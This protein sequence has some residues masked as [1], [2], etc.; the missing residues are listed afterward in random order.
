M[1]PCVRP[2]C[3][4]T[5]LCQGLCAVLCC[6]SLLLWGAEGV[7]A[8]PCPQLARYTREGFLHLGALGTTTLL[9]D[10]RCLVDTGKSRFPQLLDCDKVKSSLHKR[11][12]FIQVCLG[13][14]LG[15]LCC[16]NPGWDTAH[17][18]GWGK[19][20]TVPW[21]TAHGM[22]WDKR[23]MVPWDSKFQVPGQ[24]EG[25]K[26]DQGS[27]SRQFLMKVF[28]SGSRKVD[29]VMP[30]TSRFLCLLWMKSAIHSHTFIPKQILGP[31][32]E[33]GG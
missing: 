25:V 26:R 19:G 24:R 7:P 3:I 27:S 23:E 5:E 18:M 12:N 2:T 28:L 20:E 4:P 30:M 13:L 1:V 32:T 6:V 15:L 17:G 33:G 10:T 8:V 29:L 21:D 11:W 16:P 14:P 9:P 22:G 31:R